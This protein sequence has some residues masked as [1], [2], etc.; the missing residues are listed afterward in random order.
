MSG[1]RNTLFLENYLTRANPRKWP[2]MYLFV[3]KMSIRLLKRSHNPLLV[4][5]FSEFLEWGI[6]MH[7]N[8]QSDSIRAKVS[9]I[10]FRIPDHAL[11]I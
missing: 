2:K 1:V 10:S 11:S 4:P 5:V 7:L 6:E 8:V 3:R 9:V